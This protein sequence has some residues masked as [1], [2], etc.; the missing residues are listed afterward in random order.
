MADAITG[1][2]HHVEIWVPD[3]G[4]AIGSWSGLLESLGYSLFQEFT[5]GVSYRLGPTYIVL[6]QSKAL[7]SSEHDRCRPGLNHLAFHVESRALVDE[8][9]AK[10]Q[11]SGWTLMF[12]DRHPHAGGPDHYAAYLE[13]EDG[14]EVELAG[15]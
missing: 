11:A 7:T 12:A 1:T 9:T 15:P 5:G 2:L 4:R 6:E 14:F 3:L 10:A 13:N 8:L